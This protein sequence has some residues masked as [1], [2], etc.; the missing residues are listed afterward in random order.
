MLS[1]RIVGGWLYAMR[2][3]FGTVCIGL[4]AVLVG[5]KAVFGANGMKVWQGKRAEVQRLQQQIDQELA[6]HEQLQRH[7]DALQKEEP[8]AIEKEAREQLGYV[9]RGETVLYE[10]QPRPTPAPP[11]PGTIENN[12]RK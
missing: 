5:Y 9:K 6:T 8:S 10:Q 1:I 11:E 3:V 2:R 12:A 7:V 4:L